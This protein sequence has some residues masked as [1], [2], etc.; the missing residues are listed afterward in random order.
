MGPYY[1][2]FAI[3]LHHKSQALNGHGSR[4]NH[5]LVNL[6]RLTL[7]KAPLHTRRKYVHHQNIVE[8]ARGDLYCIY[9]F[10]LSWHI[11]QL[12]PIFTPCTNS[13]CNKSLNW[14]KKTYII[15]L[16][17]GCDVGKASSCLKD[18]FFRFSHYRNVCFHQ[19]KPLLKLFVLEGHHEGE[20]EKANLYSKYCLRGFYQRSYSSQLVI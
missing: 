19:A 11:Q 17:N 3:Y 7:K 6:K 2:V 15:T 9:H 4:I 20:K 12:R 10:N 18:Q 16:Q 8:G 5:S 13:Y 1:R 14:H